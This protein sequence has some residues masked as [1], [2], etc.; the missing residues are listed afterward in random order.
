[1]QDGRHLENRKIAISERPSAILNLKKIN[2]NGL[3]TWERFRVIVPNFVETGH[4]VAEISEFFAFVV[5]CKKLL[6]DRA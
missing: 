4:T 5:K 1:M 3:C 2:F 6:D